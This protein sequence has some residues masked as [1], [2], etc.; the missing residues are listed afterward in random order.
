MK[1]LED[2]VDMAEKVMDLTKVGDDLRGRLNHFAGA[3]KERLGGEVGSEGVDGEGDRRPVGTGSVREL[4]DGVRPGTVTIDVGPL[5]DFA[6]LT[7]L[8]DALGRI[9]GTSNVRV[10]RFSDGRATIVL[11][12]EFSTELAQ[13]LE[14]SAPYG[15]S[16]REARPDGLVLDVAEPPSE[17]Q[18]AA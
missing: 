8:E 16:I 10:A 18:R 2:A 6:Q 14:R 3:A 5:R 13:E 17:Q 11:D 15:I 7:G 12:L 4:A 1:A 9:H